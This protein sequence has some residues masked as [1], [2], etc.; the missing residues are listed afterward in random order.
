[1]LTL[2]RNKQSVWYALYTGVTDVTDSNGYKTGEKTKTYATPV[3]IKVNVSA[4]KGSA[5]TEGFG[6]N[7]D[8][9]RTIVTHD[10][11]CP[12]DETTR[13]WVD[14]DPSKDTPDPYDYRVVRVAKSLNSITIAIRKTD[15]TNPPTS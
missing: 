5:I 8:Y 11:T 7:E 3:E 14:A 2:D 4:S 12:I 13:L 9:D 6:V 10:M 15:A 1:M